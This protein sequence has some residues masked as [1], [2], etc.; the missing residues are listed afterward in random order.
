LL[1]LIP[2]A[3]FLSHAQAQTVVDEYTL[4]AGWLYQLCLYT[5]WPKEAFSSDTSP[6]VIGI[7]GKDPFGERLQGITQKR[8]NRRPIE[9]RPCTLEQAAEC[10]LVY[11]SSSEKD[12]LPNILGRLKNTH[13]LTVGEPE[14]FTRLGGVIRLA[15]IRGSVKPEISKSAVERAKLVMRSQLKECG[16]L[17]D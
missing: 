16:K 14:N 2:L 13:T 5:D 3:A 12:N 7:L 15:V 6:F 10:H 9:L 8:I 1:L 4:K 11:V 17:V